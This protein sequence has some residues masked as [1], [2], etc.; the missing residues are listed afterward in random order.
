VA[1]HAEQS[2]GSRTG[3]Y[4]STQ[5]VEGAEGTTKRSTG[6]GGDVGGT[7]CYA[8]T[9]V[10]LRL[11]VGKRSLREGSCG[12]SRRE[13]PKGPRRSCCLA[14]HST[15]AAG[16]LITQTKCKAGWA[17]QWLLAPLVGSEAGLQLRAAS[18]LAALCE[19]RAAA[20]AYLQVD[21]RRERGIAAP[22]CETCAP[23]GSVLGLTAC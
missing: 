9:L 11:T 7:L 21:S 20:A 13:N 10:V 1:E 19:C 23:V 2:L 18:L 17:C 12:L 15:A 14:Q 8:Q 22:A 3:R 5:S 16:V 4:G 6:V